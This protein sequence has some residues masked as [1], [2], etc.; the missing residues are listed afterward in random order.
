MVAMN[1][2]TLAQATS[3]GL[4]LSGSA[5][6]IVVVYLICA[7]TALTCLVAADRAD[8][9]TRAPVDEASPGDGEPAREPAEIRSRS[10]DDPRDPRNEASLDSPSRMCPTAEDPG[11]WDP[12]A[13]L[14]LL[15]LLMPSID[16]PER[17]GPA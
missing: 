6:Q 12:R 9:R 3:W 1:L 16:D 17:R 14:S 2:E 11:P 13:E 4:P 7:A 8:D 5:L 15:G 10:F